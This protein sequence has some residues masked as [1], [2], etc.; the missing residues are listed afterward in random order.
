MY[1]EGMGEEEDFKDGKY[2]T[3]RAKKILLWVAIIIVTP[4]GVL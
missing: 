4:V 3:K 1:N 2:L